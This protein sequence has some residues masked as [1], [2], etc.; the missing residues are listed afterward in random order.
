MKQDWYATLVRHMLLL[1]AG[2]LLVGLV[3]GHYGWCLALGLAVYLTWTLKQSLRLH[4]WLREHQPDQPPPDGYGLWAKCSTAS[5][6]C[7]AATSAHA[8]GCRR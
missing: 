8:G 6:T 4:R 2:C 1:V 5:I 7:N 3:T